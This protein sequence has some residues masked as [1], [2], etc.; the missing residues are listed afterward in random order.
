[1]KNF[2]YKRLCKNILLKEIT[3]PGNRYTIHSAKT[4]TGVEDAF[5]NIAR[6][7]FS[8]KSQTKPIKK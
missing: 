3:K 7:L 8:G 2:P 5:I 6:V 4:G 1:M